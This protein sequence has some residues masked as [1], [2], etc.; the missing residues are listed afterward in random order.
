MAVGLICLDKALVSLAH[1]LR[2][3][4]YSGYHIGSFSPLWVYWVA[5]ICRSTLEHKREFCLRLPA[6]AC[7]HLYIYCPFDSFYLN[8]NKKVGR[9]DSTAF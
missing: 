7:H 4:L 9:S 6:I 5:C 8:E 2:S 1:H 3:G